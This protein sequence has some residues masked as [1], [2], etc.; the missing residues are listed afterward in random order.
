MKLTLTFPVLILCSYLNLPAQE[1]EVPA[2]YEEAV[3]K[4]GLTYPAKHYYKIGVNIYKYQELKE[5]GLD[6]KEYD[7]HGEFFTYQEATVYSDVI[8]TGTIVSTD[9]D[10]DSL[11]LF[12]SFY[13]VKI[14]SCLKGNI[15]P[16]SIITICMQSGRFGQRQDQYTRLSNEPELFIGEPVFLFLSHITSEKA[17]KL[18][19]SENSKIKIPA[20]ELYSH[21]QMNA[22]FS[23][24]SDNLLN[25]NNVRVADVKEAKKTVKKIIRANSNMQKNFRD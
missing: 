19:K 20:R 11:A 21:F 25:Y 24:H 5:A 14:E 10:P 7:K 22:K 17:D 9:Y 23:I 15:L 12:H 16:D 8:I 3:K 6:L 2:S 1:I 13:K 18:N 4:L